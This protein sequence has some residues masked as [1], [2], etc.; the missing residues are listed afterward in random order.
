VW[1]VLHHYEGLQEREAAVV[2]IRAALQKNFRV[3]EQQIF[4]GT[5]GVIR[6][7]LYIRDM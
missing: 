5:T 2:A 3:S 6:V 1:L 7:L 4:S